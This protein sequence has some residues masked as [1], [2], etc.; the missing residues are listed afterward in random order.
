MVAG[1][2]RNPSR[3]RQ[4]VVSTGKISPEADRATRVAF[5]YPEKILE[6]SRGVWRT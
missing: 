1:Q 2:R 4:F 3:Q 5:W 6:E